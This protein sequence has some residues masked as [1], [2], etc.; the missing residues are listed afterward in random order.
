MKNGTITIVEVPQVLQVG[1]AFG[2]TFTVTNTG[3]ETFVPGSYKL[4]AVAPYNN[5]RWGDNR[6]QLPAHLAP[7]ASLTLRADTFRAAGASGD[8]AWQLLQEG[9]VW[10]GSPASVPIQ[11]YRPL[12][13]PRG[14]S[15]VVGHTPFATGA[16]PADGAV[17][18]LRWANPS[19]RR[20]LIGAAE[21]WIGVD[22]G[23]RCDAHAEL[24]RSDDSLLVLLQCDHY[25][26]ASR[27]AGC[28]QQTFPGQVTLEPG[29]ELFLVCVAHGF[30]APPGNVAFTASIWF[31]YG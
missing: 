11:V 12:P 30:S 8:F 4:G 27:G 16:F 25:A 26:D 7:G 9:V 1:E 6:V 13:P 23:K 24:R 17:R 19:G 2:A 29:E 18:L 31:T 14:W 28:K 22:L 10:F 20:L 5:L 21:V 15:D 3:T